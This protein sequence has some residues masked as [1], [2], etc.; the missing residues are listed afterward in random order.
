MFTSTRKTFEGE[1]KTFQSEQASTCTTG[2]FLLYCTANPVSSQVMA[3]GHKRQ[4]RI[5]LEISFKNII[6]SSASQRDDIS[7][8]NFKELKEIKFFPLN[9]SKVLL[10]GSI[11]LPGKQAVQIKYS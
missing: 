6:S 3:A 5:M 9:D 11:A 7:Q 8:S 4:E 1:Y 2:T 10:K